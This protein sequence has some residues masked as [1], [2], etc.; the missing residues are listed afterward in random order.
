[1]TVADYPPDVLD[2]AL[3]AHEAVETGWRTEQ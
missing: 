1:M 2:D 3:K